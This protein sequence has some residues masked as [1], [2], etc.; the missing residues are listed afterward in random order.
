MRAAKIITVLILAAGAG[1]TMINPPYPH[2]MY[3]QHI[4]TALLLG[5]LLVDIRFNYL[6]RAAFFGIA[7]MIGFHVLASR[8]LYTYVPYN[9]WFKTLFHFDFNE[10]FGF[11][12]NHYDRFVHFING[13]L[14]YPF[15][16]QVLGK[17]KNLTRAQTILLAWLLIQ[18]AA[19]I[20]ELFEWTLTLVLSTEAADN[21]NGQQGDWWDSQKDMALSLLS[22]SLMAIIYLFSKKKT[23]EKK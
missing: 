21:Y 18:T 12:R 3:L 17:W 2:E 1:L 5:I 13:F 7:A 11:H 14:L 6:N 4:G 20:Y 8:W 23:G 9:D 22:S 19:M 16:F 10:T 15:L